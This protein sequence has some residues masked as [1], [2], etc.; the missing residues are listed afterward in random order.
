MGWGTK[1]RQE[2]DEPE[3]MTE[4]WTRNNM[5]LWGGWIK[6]VAE[7]VAY[8]KGWTFVEFNCRNGACS[9]ASNAACNDLGLGWWNYQSTWRWWSKVSNECRKKGTVLTRWISLLI[10]GSLDG[11]LFYLVLGA[12]RAEKSPHLWHESG[13]PLVLWLAWLYCTWF[14]RSL[15]FFSWF[16]MITQPRI[17]LSGEVEITY[18]SFHQTTVPSWVTLGIHRNS[19]RLRKEKEVKGRSK[20]KKEELRQVRLSSRRVWRRLR[21]A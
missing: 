20:A 7:W 6:H 14:V 11:C 2:K 21:Q 17:I 5:A 9:G 10:T 15:F 4:R 16:G 19:L 13:K 12:F 18:T 1:K 3:N 8:G